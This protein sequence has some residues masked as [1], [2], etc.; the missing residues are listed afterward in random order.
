M[1]TNDAEVVRERKEIL[2]LGDR[3][4]NVSEACRRAGIPRSSYYN[5]RRRLREQGLSGLSNRPP[6]HNHHPLTTPRA[7]E[8]RLVELSSAHPAWGCVRLAAYLHDQGASVSAPTVQKL[9]TRHGLGTAQER[10]LCLEESVR[11]VPASC[12]AEQIAW[13]ETWNPAFQERGHES[14]C[15]G[16]TLFQDVR[17]ATRAARVY[18][19]FAVDSY[20]GL[21]FALLRP[22]RQTVDAISLLEADILPFYAQIGRPVESLVTPDVPLFWGSVRHP[23]EATLARAGIRHRAVHVADSHDNGFLERFWQDF[24]RG[25]VAPRRREWL[26]APFA[27]WQEEFSVWLEEYNTVQP[28]LGY[29]NY[30]QTPLG[31]VRGVSIEN[32]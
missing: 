4:G 30:G 8:D 15:P 13:M 11:A 21:A 3:L 26:T 20:G 2:E 9:L 29:R 5:Y 12:T 32:L 24:L 7:V 14:T 1:E 22:V 6:R 28:Y 27:G 18:V 16:E 31:F 17:H 25:F 23:F 19:H 10:W